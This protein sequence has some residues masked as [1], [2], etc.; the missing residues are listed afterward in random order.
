MNLLFFDTETTGRPRNWKASVYD[1]SNWPRVVQLA[2][3]VT[4]ME[5]DVVKKA[6]HIIRPDG[7]S[8]PQA[9]AD[10]HGITTERAMKEGV[11]LFSVLDEFHKDLAEIDQLIGHNVSFDYNVLGCEYIRVIAENPL[12]A[13]ES[14]CTMKNATDYCRIPGPYGYKWPTLEELHFNLFQRGF[15]DA[16]NAMADVQA[17]ADS[18]FE[19]RRLGVF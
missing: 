15:E 12:E 8:I 4:S 13:Y 3:I 10:V 7:F 2:W 19:L 1:T 17:T 16:H 14:F 9:A 5:G 11:T 6:D 18:Y